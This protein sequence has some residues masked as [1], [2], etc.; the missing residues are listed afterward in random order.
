MLATVTWML[1]PSS[2]K[3]AVI[4]ALTNTPGKRASS[5]SLTPSIELWSVSVT[6]PMPCR[7]SSWYVAIGS[8]YDSG[9]ANVFAA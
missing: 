1:Q 6:S 9:I 7:R 8:L 5:I 4:S 3:V 2:G